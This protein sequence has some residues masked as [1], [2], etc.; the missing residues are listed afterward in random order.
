M[1]IGVFVLALVGTLLLRRATSAK[2]AKERWFHSTLRVFFDALFAFALISIALEIPLIRDML[3]EEMK[4]VIDVQNNFRNEIYLAD[5]FSEDDLTDFRRTIS[6]TLSKREWIEGEESLLDSLIYPPLSGPIATDLRIIREQDIRYAEDNSKYFAVRETLTI[7]YHLPEG[8]VKFPLP[9]YNELDTIPGVQEDSLYHLENFCINGKRLDPFPVFNIIKK[10]NL[11][12]F[13]GRERY[14]ILTP[15]T[16]TITISF[17][18]KKL[19]PYEDQ[20][21]MW[22]KRPTKGL[23]ISLKIDP[24]LKPKLY[25]FALGKGPEESKPTFQLGDVVTWKYENWLFQHHGWVLTWDEPGN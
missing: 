24:R 4:R 21:L 25:L 3:R 15:G 19:I 5:N 13:D 17:K 8:T 6:K 1:G 22:V 10:H 14:H 18:C 2:E 20:W 9:L 11:V 12:I 7:T 16:N 23:E